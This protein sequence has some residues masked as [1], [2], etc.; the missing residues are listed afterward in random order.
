[1]VSGGIGKKIPMLQV[2]LFSDTW[3]SSL[4]V[5][6][7]VPGRA[8]I[9]PTSRS[10]S[11]TKPGPWSQPVEEPRSAVTAPD[12]CSWALLLLILC[13]P[14]VP[15]FSPVFP[16]R[17][18]C[19]CPFLCPTHPRLVPSCSLFRFHLNITLLSESSLKKLPKSR[20]R[21]LIKP[22][23]RTLTFSLKAYNLIWLKAS[24]SIR[25]F[26]CHRFLLPC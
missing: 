22:L 12:T 9:S 21:S 24:R 11:A 16:S 13:S 7:L 18:L 4:K 25:P 6:V 5:V 10:S 2:S 23:Y 14:A 19:T 3:I 15:T 8:W 26:W 1:M 20:S 17:G